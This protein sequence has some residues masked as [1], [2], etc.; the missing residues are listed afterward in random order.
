MRAQKVH[1][2]SASDLEGNSK[3]EEE[4]K[5]MRMMNNDGEQQ[6]KIGVQAEQCWDT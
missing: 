4:E 2:F 6:G 1:V 3:E 5:K